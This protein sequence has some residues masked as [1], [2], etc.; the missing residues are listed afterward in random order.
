MID[1][2]ESQRQQVLDIFKKYLPDTPVWVFGSRIKGT[3][4][5]Y[6]DL[7]LAL[8]TKQPLTIRQQT[9]L[10]LAF[11]DS[12]LPFTVD[13]IDGASCNESFKQIILQRYE[14]LI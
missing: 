2:T 13:L 9:E 6:S 10:E 5:A 7:D 4:K 8:I 3:A 12:D 11:T 1:L 14:V